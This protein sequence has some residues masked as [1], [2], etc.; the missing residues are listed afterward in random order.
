MA[1]K[2]AT[3]ALV[4]TRPETVLADYARLLRAAGVPA[5][6]APGSRVAFCL[7]LE[8]DGRAANLPPAVAPPWLLEGVARSL[9]A[10]GWS[11]ADLSLIVPGRPAPA[12]PLSWRRVISGCGIA[13]AQSREQMPAAPPSAVLLSSLTTH[14]WLGIAGSLG[15]LAAHLLLPADRLAL[16][17]QPTRLSEAWQRQG[18]VAVGGAVIDATICGAGPDRRRLLPL[19][20]HVL[21]GGQDPVAVDAI[22]A[23]LIG[24]T[25]LQLPLLRAAHAAGL[26]CADPARIRLVGDRI[27]AWP[28]LDLRAA[29]GYRGPRAAEP[30]RWSRLFTARWPRVAWT[31]RAARRQRQ[32]FAATAWGRLYD[33]YER[34]EQSAQGQP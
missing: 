14:R 33:H 8:P 24:F 11:A 13:P 15:T 30:A 3:V 2:E 29:A 27:D 12:L 28:L 21:V 18:R 22:A 7:D 31:L 6:V 4:R 20:A 23:S 19:A 25:P 1:A 10:Q 16:D 5:A 34:P 17:R 9:L 32:R 26:G